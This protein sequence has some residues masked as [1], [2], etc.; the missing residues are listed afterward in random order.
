VS[1]S[2]KVAMVVPFCAG[3]QGLSGESRLAQTTILLLINVNIE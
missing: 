3:K 1:P 2:R